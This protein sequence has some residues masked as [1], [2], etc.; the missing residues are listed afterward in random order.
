MSPVL[1]AFA[2]LAS[3]PEASVLQAGPAAQSVLARGVE[4]RLANDPELAR[5]H[6]VSYSIL[7]VDQ[8]WLLFSSA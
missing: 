1:V 8:R 6:K 3:E 2:L 7:M 5:H 4:K